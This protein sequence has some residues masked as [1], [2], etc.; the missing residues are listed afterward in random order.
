[1]VEVDP[2]GGGETTTEL[3]T[4]RGTPWKGRQS[5][6]PAKK[7]Q[8]SSRSSSTK[9]KKAQRERQGG[10]TPRPNW[11]PYLPRTCSS[12]NLEGPSTAPVALNQPNTPLGAIG[13]QTRA[14]HS[15][16][17]PKQPHI[18]HPIKLQSHNFRKKKAAG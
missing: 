12:Q 17:L 11:S 3:H 16:T 6:L 15:G 2:P 1:E 14:H 8:Q 7:C 9:V 5:T 10:E 4:L 13:H 18:Q